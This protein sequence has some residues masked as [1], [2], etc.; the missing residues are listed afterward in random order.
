MKTYEF[1]DAIR[2]L[3]AGDFSRLEPLFTDDLSNDDQHCQIIEWHKAGLFTDEQA[4]LNEALTCA[5]FLGKTSVAEYLLAQGLNPA[6]GILTGLNA[7]HWAANRGQLETVQLLIRHQA[8]LETRNMYGGTV[9]GTTV[10]SAINEPRP[11]HFRIMEALIKAGARLAESGYP[12][13]DE[14]VDAVLKRGIDFAK[15]EEKKT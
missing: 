14:R 13:G 5:C 15:S 4:A 3:I 9:L 6:G 10:W 1:K 2:G 8:P 12:T 11:D 7:F